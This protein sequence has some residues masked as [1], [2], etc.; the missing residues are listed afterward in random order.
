MIYYRSIGRHFQLY[1]SDWRLFSVN[2]IKQ[3]T[4]TKS[5]LRFSF[6]LKQEPNSHAFFIGCVTKYCLI[7][8]ISIITLNFSANIQTISHSSKLFA[9]FLHKRKSSG[10]YLPLPINQFQTIMMKESYWQ[11]HQPE[12]VN[13][14]T[15]PYDPWIAKN[16]TDT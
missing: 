9:N 7:V 5:I 10:S 8:P 4:S 12:R 13:Q 3:P 11:V 2:G 14:C 16:I 6:L 15:C 1:W